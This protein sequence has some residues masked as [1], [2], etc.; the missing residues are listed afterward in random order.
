[1]RKRSDLTPAEQKFIE[2]ASANQADQKTIKEDMHKYVRRMLEPVDDY[3]PDP[4]MAEGSSLRKDLTVGLTES[5][6]NTVDRH[7]KAIGVQKSTWVRHALLKLI[8]EEQ[9]YCFK[10]RSLHG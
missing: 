1:M 6:W 4:S 10:N 7:V 2:G 5:Q 3:K 9:T 8:E